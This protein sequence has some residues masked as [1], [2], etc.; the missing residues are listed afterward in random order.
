MITKGAQRTRRQN[1]VLFVVL[2]V[3]FVTLHLLSVL[4]VTIHNSK[5]QG[6]ING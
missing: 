5:L 6:T 2:L 4:L 1:C 3:V